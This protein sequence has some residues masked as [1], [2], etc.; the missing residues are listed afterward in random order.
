MTPNAEI[1]QRKMVYERRS[2]TCDYISPQLYIYIRLSFIIM[3]KKILI[4]N[5]RI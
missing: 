2:T 1:V 5:K 4:L 3:I